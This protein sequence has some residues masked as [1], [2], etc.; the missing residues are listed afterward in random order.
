MLLLTECECPYRRQEHAESKKRSERVTGENTNTRFTGAQLRGKSAG[1]EHQD[2][3]QS[4]QV[5]LPRVRPQL[6]ARG[7]PGRS[8]QQRPRRRRS[9][10]RGQE[11]PRTSPSHHD[12]EN[13]YRNDAP[14]SSGN[15]QEPPGESDP[16]EPEAAAVEFRKPRRDRPRRIAQ[17]PLP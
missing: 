12:A 7:C 9:V 6:H 10:G 5:R 16:G 2:D 3:W 17:G 8:P 4:R 13:G 14:E 1:H 11:E 15:D